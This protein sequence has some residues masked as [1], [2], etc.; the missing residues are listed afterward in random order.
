MPLSVRLD[1]KTESVVKRLARRHKQTQSAV[2]REA[3]AA[4]ARDEAAHPPEPSSPWEALRHLVGVANSE[5]GRLSQDTGE[6]FRALVQ[7]KARA[8][9]SR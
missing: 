9:R 3:I 8:R 2:V 1:P 4:Y 7:K 5:D 6:R